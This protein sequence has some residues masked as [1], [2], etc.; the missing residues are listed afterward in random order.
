MSK[1]TASGIG[2]WTGNTERPLKN[3][4]PRGLKG[5]GSLPIVTAK[6]RFCLLAEGIQ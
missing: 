3:P 1:S 4:K 6:A 2:T 5:R